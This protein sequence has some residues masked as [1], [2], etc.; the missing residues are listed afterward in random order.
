[1]IGEI[2]EALEAVGETVEKVAEGVGTVTQAAGTVAES[3]SSVAETAGTVAESASNVVEAGASSAQV[4]ENAL[5]FPVESMN[6]IGGLAQSGDPR[7]ALELVANPSSIVPIQNAEITSAINDISIQQVQE[8]PP[9]VPENNIIEAKFSVKD[10]AP[11]NPGGE[12]S[13]IDVG[14]KVVAENIS[15]TLPLKVEEA[16]DVVPQ[17]EVI[18]VP[19]EVKGSVDEVKFITDE[20]ERLSHEA[21]KKWGQNYSEVLTN[22]VLKLF[23][24]QGEKNKAQYI[25]SG[26]DVGVSIMHLLTTLLTDATSVEQVP[27]ILQ[28]LSHELEDEE[29]ERQVPLKKTEA[30]TNQASVDSP[31]EVAAT[32]EQTLPTPELGTGVAGALPEPNPLNYA[33]FAAPVTEA[34]GSVASDVASSVASVAE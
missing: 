26:R 14:G 30:E 28:Q 27:I 7:G 9:V 3:A 8:V 23:R 1:M 24:D 33:N 6:A 10:I 13:L 25:T 20:T 11:V 15:N 18:D 2:G 32:T 12:G 19:F 22:A 31:I 34:V 21:E 29:E 16:V 5:E 17:N 4:A